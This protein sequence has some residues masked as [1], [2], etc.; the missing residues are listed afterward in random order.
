MDGSFIN[1]IITDVDGKVISKEDFVRNI[2][3]FKNSLSSFHVKEQKITNVWFNFEKGEASVDID[4]SY[5][6]SLEGVKKDISQASQQFYS[7][8]STGF[9]ALSGFHS[10]I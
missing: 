2:K 6:A 8:W 7:S 10:W 9:G 3:I 4:L 5:D 1:D